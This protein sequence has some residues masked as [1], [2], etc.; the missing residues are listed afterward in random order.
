MACRRTL[1]ALLGP[2]ACVALTAPVPVHA[3]ARQERHECREH[4]D[5]AIAAC[6]QYKT[7]P[8]STA[9]VEGRRLR[10]KAKRIRRLCT[11]RALRRCRRTGPAACDQPLFCECEG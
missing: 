3:D 7:A 8:L 11:K 4:C 2:I 1:A 10:R 9:A 6:I 5:A